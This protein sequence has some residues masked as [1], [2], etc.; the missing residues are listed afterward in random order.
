MGGGGGGGGDDLANCANCLTKRRH[1][2]NISSS[3]QL[4]SIRDVSYLNLRSQILHL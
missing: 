1:G 4:N 2:A 3:H